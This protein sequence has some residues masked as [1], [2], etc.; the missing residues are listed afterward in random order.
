MRFF[1]GKCR[2]KEQR[3]GTK[4]WHLSSFVDILVC[5]TFIISDLTRVSIEMIT[6]IS[7]SDAVAR[8]IFLFFDLTWRLSIRTVGWFLLVVRSIQLQW[9]EQ[10]VIRVFLNQSRCFWRLCLWRY[11]LIAVPSMVNVLLSFYFCSSPFVWSISIQFNR[12]SSI[13]FLDVNLFVRITTLVS[14]RSNEREKN[15]SSLLFQFKNGQQGKIQFEFGDEHGW[16]VEVSQR[17]I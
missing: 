7:C 11:P 14:F 9:F 17:T 12:Y 6:I 3:W 13:L 16:I 4:H 10:S 1:V 2:W 8:N 15:H 5:L